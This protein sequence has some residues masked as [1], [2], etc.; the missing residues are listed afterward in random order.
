MLRAKSNASTNLKYY[1]TRQD[2]IVKDCTKG[3]LY[4]FRLM[5]YKHNEHNIKGRYSFI[6][7]LLLASFVNSQLS[8][9]SG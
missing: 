7:S 9:I 8:I 5:W 6:S 4:C 3:I 1:N 2:K